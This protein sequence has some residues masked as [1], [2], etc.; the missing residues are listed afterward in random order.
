MNRRGLLRGL[1]GAAY[2]MGLTEV[3]TALGCVA[4][5]ITAWAVLAWRLRDEAEV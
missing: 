2:A 1:P 5:I 3:W 4:G